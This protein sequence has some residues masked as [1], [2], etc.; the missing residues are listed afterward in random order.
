MSDREKLE[1]MARELLA[2]NAMQG[3]T[4]GIVAIADTIEKAV[5]EATTEHECPHHSNSISCE[6]FV[7][8]QKQQQAEIDRLKASHAVL[9]NRINELLIE[10]DRLKSSTD[11]LL[12]QIDRLKAELERVKSEKEDL[13]QSIQ[14]A[15]GLR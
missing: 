2:L 9:A 15:G 10:I 8:F 1:Q 11:P 14:N 7:E 12:K 5:A 13:E 6:G 3:T 4:L